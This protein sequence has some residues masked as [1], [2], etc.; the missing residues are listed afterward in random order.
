MAN[1]DQDTSLKALIEGELPQELVFDPITDN[2]ST[3]SCLGC[4]YSFVGAAAVLVGMYV[5]AA[6]YN[7][8]AGE[9]FFSSSGSGVIFFSALV[10]TM[11]L[12]TVVEACSFKEIYVLVTEPPRLELRRRR[13][14]RSELI[15]SWGV[16]KLQRF[17]L[18]EPIEDEPNARSCLYVGIHQEE[19]IRL[20][21]A[22]YPRDFVEKIQRRVS[23]I[24]ELP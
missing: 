22:S 19:P 16:E 11:V 21:E 2:D 4:A 8:E 12:F 6:R 20:L 24:C 17:F 1:L 18:D 5:A 23:E 7:W 9:R 10:V 13:W 3:G 15:R 14:A